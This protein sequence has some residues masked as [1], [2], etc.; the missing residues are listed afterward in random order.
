MENFVK[1]NHRFRI[2]QN[3]LCSSTLLNLKSDYDFWSNLLREESRHF[4]VKS[5]WCKMTIFSL[6][7]MM[8]F[9]KSR[10]LCIKQSCHFKPVKS[11]DSNFSKGTRIRFSQMVK[12]VI[13][14]L[15]WLSWI[16]NF[17]SNSHT[18]KLD[19]NWFRIIFWRHSELNLAQILGRT[20]NNST[21]I[22]Q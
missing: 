16:P 17:I 1:K 8:W 3:M 11:V 5:F 6:Q 9:R 21:S 13:K 22:W 12:I 18:V 10:H 2:R 19:Q 14:Y 15:S 20:D 7:L 4:D